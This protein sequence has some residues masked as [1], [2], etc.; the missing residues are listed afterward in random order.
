[1]AA[2]AMVFCEKIKSESQVLYQKTKLWTTFQKIITLSKLAKIQCSLYWDVEK[3]FLFPSE[4]VKVLWK[5]GL[6]TKKCL[7]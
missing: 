4:A 5:G 3:L 7:D 1:M 6:D 2:M